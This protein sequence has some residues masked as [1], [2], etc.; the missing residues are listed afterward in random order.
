MKT[1]RLVKCSIAALIAAAGTMIAAQAQNVGLWQ[2]NGNLNSANG[3]DPITELF[4][5]GDFGSTESFAIGAINGETAQ[6]M[7]FPANTED[8]TGFVIPVSTELSNSNDYTFMADVYYPSASNGTGRGLADTSIDFAGSELGIGANNALVAAGGSGVINPDT[9]HRVIITVDGTNG[10]ITRYVDGVL[11]GSG[12]ISSDELPFGRYTLDSQLDVIA[13][14]HTSEGFVNSVQLRKDVITRGHAAALGGASADGLPEDLPEVTPFI[15][16][17]TPS[18]SVA[19]RNT[20]IGVMINQGDA[21]IDNNSIEF[22][23]DDVAQNA[24]ISQAGGVITISVDRSLPFAP[25]TKHVLVVNFTDDKVGAQSYSHEFDAAIYFEDFE[26]AVLEPNV[27]EGLES[28]KA[29][30]RIGMTGWDVDDSGV[31]GVGDDETDGVTEW[32]GWSFANKEWWIQA[33]G[34]QRR[35]E[36][37]FA[38]GTVL[39]ADPDEWDDQGHADSEE[40]GWYETYVTSPEVSLE[41]I[42]PG[43]AFLQMASSWRDEFDSNYR[44]SVN[45]EVSFDG[46]EWR[47][48][49][50]WVS[51]PASPNFHDDAPNEML[52]LQ[53]D[54]PEG[55]QNVVMKFGMFDAG[56]D[57]WWAIDNLVV[58]AGATPPTLVSHPQAIEVDE[59]AEASFT[60]EVE[61][62]GPFNYEWFLNG[63]SI[64][65][66]QS[67]EITDTLIISRANADAA[68]NY[69]VVVSNAGGQTPPSNS[70]L[71]EVKA[72]LPGTLLFFEGFEGLPLGPNIDE[73]VAGD[74]VWTDTLPDGWDRV[75]DLPGL[76]DDEVGVREWEGWAFADRA[77]WANTAGDQ[78]RTEF[79][80]GTGT[81]AIADGDEWDDKGSPAGQGTMNTMMTTPEISLAEVEAGTLSL[82]FNSSWRPEVLQTGLVEASFDGGA[83][84]EI[85]RFSSQDDDNYK[86]H[87]PN[88]TV[89]VSIDHPADASTMK[90]TFS[91]LEAG[92][93]WWWAIDNIEV[94]GVVPNN[95]IL[96]T[97]DFD[98][99][100]LGPNVDESVAGDAVWT[101]TAPAGWSIDDSGVPGVGDPA[102]DGVTEW[103]G[104]SFASKDWWVEAAGDQRRSE[105]V[106]STG[107]AAIADGDEWDDQDHAEG[108]L[109]TFMSTGAIDISSAPER[110]LEL[111]FDSSW[112][113]EYDSYYRQTANVTVSFDGGAPMEVML[114]ESNSESPN[115]HDANTNERV[116]LSVAN[117]AGAQTMVVT[118]GYFDAGN[119]WWW[120][121]D[122]I[123]VAIGEP[124]PALVP[125][126]EDFSNLV[127]GPNVDEELAGDAVWTK[128]APSGWSIDDSGVPGVGIPDQDGVTEWAGWSFAD[129]DWWAEATGDQR[130]SEFTKASGTIAIADG[131][132]WDDQDHAEGYLNTFMSWPLDVSG[133]SG[134]LELRFDSSW[135]PEYDSYYRQTANITVSFDGGEPMEVMLWESNSDSPNFHDANTNESV[136]VSLPDPA[137]AKNMVITFGY[138]D[139]GNDWWWAIDNLMVF[140]AYTVGSIEG[141]DG[142]VL[143]PNVDE[144]L[145][146]DAVWTKTAPGGWSID[147]SGV[148][149]VGI[150]DQDGVTEWAGWSF[151]DKDWWA[152]A[153]GDQRRSEF[154]KATGTIAI[155][156]GDEWDD[157]DHAEGYL[158]TFM[159]WPVTISGA[160][161]GSL[162]LHFDSSWRPEYDSYYRQTANVTVSYDGAD[163]VEVMLWESNSDSPNFHDANTNESVVVALNNPAGAKSAVVTFGYFDAGN[164]WWWAIDNVRIVAAGGSGI[165]I[166]AYG[167]F[168]SGVTVTWENGA[169]E[170]APAV[171]GPWTPVEGAV[172]PYTVDWDQGVYTYFANADDAFGLPYR[173]RQLQYESSDSITIETYQDTAM[174]IPSTMDTP[175][176]LSGLVAEDELNYRAE[177]TDFQ[178]QFYNLPY[179]QLGGL[180]T[181]SEDYTSLTVDI[182]TNT[183]QIVPDETKVEIQGLAAAFAQVYIDPDDGRVH[184]VLGPFYLG[185]QK[186]FRAR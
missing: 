13:F 23:L 80:K 111:S 68:G 75:N 34:D 43:T 136:V 45:I 170:S 126:S 113:P 71:L 25:A 78:R 24:Q 85:L 93:N 49:H 114:W 50:R 95:N 20:D 152:Q 166:A 94:K 32:A 135:R 39:V 100:A 142:L 83:P 145:A 178:G 129:K 10:V 175:V 124:Q 112:R 180:V 153:T 103:A 101:K 148:P 64:A 6:I 40:N 179:T 184:V 99:L 155:A 130:R 151:A 171:T 60:V 48:I 35:S 140:E 8:D 122:N 11:T 18:G 167:E 16:A 15:E 117:P 116:V 81:I 97:E 141:F 77:W 98:G 66:S 123:T 177:L 186:F 109:D 174:T 89:T 121:I 149:G 59:G 63:D 158:N 182:V 110:T 79:V 37:S 164:D 160:A 54:N 165:S 143:G 58:N 157:Q 132:E 65:V 29:W 7:K 53:L 33:A 154:T 144:E 125:A 38:S 172:S 139:A 118:F 76:D 169:L 120:A 9:W 14:A 46:G 162:E 163:P 36:F 42:A 44:Q 31:P 159:S 19:D 21:Q 28:D 61:G 22:L 115:F 90:L 119:D 56:N 181:Y 5:S 3:G 72:S 87:A 55:A 127:L 1:K 146:G 73:G 17:W 176:R 106:N 92:N 51:D 168:F 173:K 133:V 47:E 183:M 88:D 134:A 91:Y 4:T 62:T 52:I 131:D 156:D 161:E 70:A 185:G 67:I 41:G 2:L 108:Y 57:W 150:P 138:F 12:P 104:W 26:S 128:T 102:Q 137:G 107:I 105:F 84:V 147:D 27:N 96:F 74:A 30:T 82:R 69:S 86:G